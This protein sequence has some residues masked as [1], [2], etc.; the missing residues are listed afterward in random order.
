MISI[1]QARLNSKRLPGKALKLINGKP[2]LFRVIESLKKSK[3]IKQIFIATSNSNGDK[4]IVKFCK[5][6]K[7]DF[8]TG[9]LEDVSNRFK[10]FLEKN[11]NQHKSFVRINGDSPLIDHKLVD[12]CI[13]LFKKKKTKYFNQCISQNFS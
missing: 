1:V 5:K 6:N 4:K 2:M 12:K 11:F 13:K 10:V 9:N 8:F 7:F 3:Q